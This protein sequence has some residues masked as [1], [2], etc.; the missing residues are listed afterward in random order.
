L[1]R[2]TKLTRGFFPPEAAGIGGIFQPDLRVGADRTALRACHH[3]L[4]IATASMALAG[5]IR[6]ADD[7]SGFGP[8]HPPPLP[9]RHKDLPAARHPN[10]AAAAQRF[11]PV[12]KPAPRD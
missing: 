3:L 6:P 7:A 8:R 1:N 12:A 11:E 10:E 2:Q 5:R 4:R 9:L